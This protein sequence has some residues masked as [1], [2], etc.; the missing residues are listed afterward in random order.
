M[1]ELRTGQIVYPVQGY[2]GYGDGV[3]TDLTAF[4]ADEMRNDWATNRDALLKFWKSGEYTTP[5]VFP[6]SLPW[7][8]VRGYAR[9]YG[10]ISMRDDDARSRAPECE[11]R[12]LAGCNSRQ[13]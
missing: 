4:I 8:F 13:L 5:D 11:Q 7:P 2:T 12:S 1:G 3:G 6:D 9:R 10:P